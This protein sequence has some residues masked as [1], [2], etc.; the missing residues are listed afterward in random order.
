MKPVDQTREGRRGNCM[1]A[2]V[3]SIF[4]ENLES[5]TPLRLEAA[6]WQTRLQ[7][8]LSTEGLGYVEAGYDRTKL[9]LPNSGFCILTGPNS[10][11]RR[12][13]ADHAVVGLLGRRSVKMVH[14][15]HPSREGLKSVRRIGWFVLLDPD[16][17][18]P[19]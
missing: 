12:S 14:D 2:V 17:I 13:G 5:I 6:G 11:S 15:P 8:W 3:A 9:V 18:P 16:T 4:H 1:T 10:R 7:A 19:F